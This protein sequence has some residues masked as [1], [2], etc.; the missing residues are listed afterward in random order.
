M[1]NDHL[2]MI[3]ML[4]RAGEKFDTWEIREDNFGAPIDPPGMTLVLSSKL[5]P[6]DTFTEFTF[7]H[8]GRLE[9]VTVYNTQD[10]ANGY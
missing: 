6:D 7:D 8:D 9:S 10:E 5:N 1:T 2:R 3:Q 4:G